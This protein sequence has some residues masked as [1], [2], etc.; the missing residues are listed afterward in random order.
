MTIGIVFTAIVSFFIIDILCILLLML[1]CNIV[2]SISEL[3]KPNTVIMLVVWFSLVIF[4]F[5]KVLPH[6]NNLLMLL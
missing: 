5:W 1:L 6:L 4:I 2:E 3:N